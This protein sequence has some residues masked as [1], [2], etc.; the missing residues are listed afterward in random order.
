MA[1]CLGATISCAEASDIQYRVYLR[2]DAPFLITLGHRWRRCRAVLVTD[3]AR[4][5]IICLNRRRADPAEQ[6]GTKNQRDSRY[7]RLNAL[8]TIHRSPLFH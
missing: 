3:A 2:R 6:H 7:P 4:L 1:V 5:D 8:P